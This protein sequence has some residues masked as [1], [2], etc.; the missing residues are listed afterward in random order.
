VVVH[1]LNPAYTHKAWRTQVPRLAQAAI[2]V[3]RELGATLLVPGNIYNFG[4]SM[5][6]VLRE[7]TVQSAAT[8]KGRIR[9]AMER[10]V[11]EA[12]Q[13][14]RMKAVVIRAG[15]FFGAGRGAWLDLVLAN[16]LARGELT[17]PGA[18]DVPT[19]WAYLPDLAAAFVKVAQQRRQL[20]AFDTLHFAGHSITGQDW[21]E[22]LRDVAWEEGWLPPSGE[23]RVKALSWP[24]MRAAG[25]FVPTLA[26]L[27]EMRYL[28]RT[29]H[30][31]DNARLQALIGDEPH[32]PFA[33]ALRAALADLDLLFKSQAMA[34]E[35]RP[36]A[37]ATHSAHIPQ[38]QPAL[39]RGRHRSA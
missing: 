23:L 9:I 16:N 32:T 21:A 31:L 26:A 18:L 3:T 11:L 34:T 19:A 2:R 5:P 24:L 20:P 4:E 25:L 39:R 12:T 10:Q 22:T 30:R 6:A 27:C 15:D 29:P 8:V 33:Q 38:W 17:Y 7:D 28:W 13:D 35:P 1:A 37:T 36:A 14:G